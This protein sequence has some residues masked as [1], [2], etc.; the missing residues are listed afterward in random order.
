MWRLTQNKI[1]VS[2][3]EFSRSVFGG[4]VYSRK[5]SE[6]STLFTDTKAVSIA[7]SAKIQRAY[8]H[9]SLKAR[10]NSKYSNNGKRK[11]FQFLVDRKVKSLQLRSL[12]LNFSAL[13]PLV[14]SFS[15]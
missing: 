3:F 1:C 7:K 10:G 4:R 14:S 6:I 12:S 9:F 13:C 5:W 2:K 8:H 11:K 15:N